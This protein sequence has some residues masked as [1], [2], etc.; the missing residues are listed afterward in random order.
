[1]SNFYSPPENISEDK[2]LITDEESFHIAKVLRKESG[3]IIKV[4]DG[5]GMEYTGRIETVSVERTLVRIVSKRRKPC[6]PLLEV[7][8]A[9][10]VPRG[11]GMGLVV[12]KCTEIGVFRIIPLVTKNSVAFPGVNK[13]E[14]WRNIA[15]SAMKQSGRAILPVV[16]ELTELSSVS[17]LLKNY[18]LKLVGWEREEKRTLDD[19]PLKENQKRAIVFIGPEGGFTENEIEELEKLG[20]IPVS[21]GP[22]KLKTETASIVLLALLLNKSGDLG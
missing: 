6:E 18:K 16:D 3:E 4:V 14:R 20:V 17:K 22:R 13:L 8:L 21:V 11:D 5:F 12:E 7:T 2:I 10:G 1:M 9:C 19:I 15:V